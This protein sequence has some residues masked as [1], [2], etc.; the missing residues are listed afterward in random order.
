MERPAGG[1]RRRSRVARSAQ[2]PEPRRIDPEPLPG[3]PVH[4]AVGA[5][6]REGAVDLRDGD[7]ATPGDADHVAAAELDARRDGTEDAAAAGDE[8]PDRIRVDERCVTRAGLD[9]LEQPI[10]RGGEDRFQGGATVPA[11]ARRRC[12]ARRR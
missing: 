10:V 6:P 12:R 8:P 9:E 1:D 4:G 5:H 2:G 3:E 7:G 11:I